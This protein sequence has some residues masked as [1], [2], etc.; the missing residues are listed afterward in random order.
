MSSKNFLHNLAKPFN[1]NTIQEFVAPPGATRL[2]F[3][4]L[5]AVGFNSNPGYYND[6]TGA[7]AVD[8]LIAPPS[9]NNSPVANAGPD[10]TVN[11]GASVTLD[12]TA[13]SDPDNDPLTYQWTI[14]SGPPGGIISNQNSAVAT[15]N[16]PT[17]NADS[18]ATL[19]LKVND[20]RGGTDTDTVNVIVKNVTI[21]PPG[22]NGKIAFM[23][24]R[25]GFNQIYTM[26][27]D[28]TSQTRISTNIAADSM[29]SWSPDKT[30]IAFASYVGGSWEIYTMNADGTG[31]TRLTNNG[32]AD[33]EPSWSPDKTKIA[34]TS[35][36]DGTWKIYTMNADGT[37]QTIL[38]NNGGLEPTWSPDG[39]KIAFSRSG[40]IYVINIDGSGSTNLTNFVGLDRFSSWSPDG[41][42]IAFETTR[43]GNSEIY[44]MNAD[45]TNPTNLS[46]H[47]G[48]DSD[49]SFS[50]DGTKIA[51]I[52]DRSDPFDGDIFTMNSNGSG[53]TR[54]TFTGEI[55][56]YPD[57]GSQAKQPG[58][59]D[60]VAN[61]GPD[62]TVTEGASVTLNGSNSSDPDND[63]LTY[64]WTILSG[65][66]GG[67]ISNQNSA[68]AT[69]NA[70]TVNA[71][72]AAT[73]QLKVNDG[74]GG[75]DTDPV[76]V[77]VKNAVAP[78]SL[79]H[80]TQLGGNDAGHSP[81]HSWYYGQEGT[82]N[83]ETGN[84]NWGTLTSVEVDL[85]S[86]SAASLSF[87][88]FLSK[89]PFSFVDVASV[90]ISQNG[91]PFT[92]IWTQPLSTTGWK[93][94]KIDLSAFDG[95][96]IRAQFKFDTI[97]N[98]FNNFEGWYIDDISISGSTGGPGN[99]IP[100]ANA[101]P[102]QSVNEGT[103]VTLDGS[104]SFDTD[105]TITAYLWQQTAGPLVKFNA[106]TAKPIFTAPLVS[107][108]T[109]LAFQLRVT[110][111]KGA[112]SI[113][114]FVN[115]TVQDVQPQPVLDLLAVIETDGNPLDIAINE[116]FGKLYVL[117]ED[118]F[119]FGANKVAKLHV[120]DVNDESNIKFEKVFGLLDIG[121]NPSSV[122]IHQK[123]NT[124]YVVMTGANQIIRIQ[125]DPT[126]IGYNEFIQPATVPIG[127][128]TRFH[129]FGR[130]AI[131]ETNN[132]GYVMDPGTNWVTRFDLNPTLKPP[133]P[134]ISPPQV[135]PPEQNYP[136][137]QSLAFPFGAVARSD[138]S[139]NLDDNGEGNQFYIV[140]RERGGLAGDAGSLAIYNNEQKGLAIIPEYIRFNTGLTDIVIDEEKNIAYVALRTNGIATVDIDPKKT[141]SS[142]QD[143]II[144]IVSFGSGFT[145]DCPEQPNNIPHRAYWFLNCSL[146]INTNTDRIY[147]TETHAEGYG[148]VVRVI[149]ANTLQ[150]IMV[151]G[152]DKPSME[153]L[154]I[155]INEK[156]GRA[157][158]SFFSTDSF[159]YGEVII[160][161]IEK[162]T[163]TSQ[164]LP[165][166]D[167]DSDG[168]PDSKDVCPDVP[169]TSAN[170]GC[171]PLTGVDTIP[172]LV[173]TPGDITKQATDSSGANVSFTATA[174][175]NVNQILTTSCTPSPGSKFTVGST[176]VVCSVTDSAGNS[177][178]GTFTVTVQSSATTPP[179]VIPNWIKDV[180]AFWCADQIDD[181]SFIQAIQYL[182][183]NQI[184][185]VPQAQS[186]IAGGEQQVPQWVKNNACWWSQG[187]ITN[188]DFAGGIQYLIKIGVIVV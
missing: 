175:D 42:K 26:N 168:I 119:T 110:D 141:F 2:Y 64:Q 188:S 29:P 51:F 8:V 135:N 33:F 152:S 186:G 78:T 147:Y 44:T 61:A 127:T 70:P 145:S 117:T 77:T 85:T 136:P 153:P 123:S 172:P 134:P 16:A 55:D 14:L 35:N 154:E 91:G 60:P 125:G 7:I 57:W 73:L 4:F 5:D 165:E 114:D 67:T 132:F 103:T 13:S 166:S 177:A 138:N 45:G 100:I 128:T 46:N 72:S 164:I 159:R 50:P 30:K 116:K 87:N 106:V 65:P 48:Y 3:G 180:A 40:D 79:W 84:R 120:F 187:Q 150:T 97:D 21:T 109:V 133:V 38:T 58:N 148:G 20:G 54:L 15:Y 1:T 142:P 126:K 93:S 86:Q 62:K 12:G 90:L 111:D 89:E 170:N 146:E 104:F 156:T 144:D 32:A 178:T 95:S 47:P 63:P 108:N 56:I 96:K 66:P 151:D 99:K 24:K 28:G 36:R 130:I 176:Q 122:E 22:G 185:I 68:V 83:Y 113:P 10:K 41:T 19:Q 11:E 59:N 6:N 155:D 80:I 25:D 23:S 157:Y 179:V 162:T 75:T 102:D 184:I 181:S 171:P 173:L 174:I 121:V 92:E 140:N 31:R 101:G 107:A 39:S 94:V 167:R 169:G 9:A 160:Y 131:D 69:Y 18:A 139:K 115:I 149:D 158:V 81:T 76:N 88:H 118:T 49:P 161:A 74:R 27:P 53:Q 52:S 105:G 137:Y 143:R 82:N 124:V 112:T 98:Q 17:V 129:A 182:L 37:G 71:D 34:F 183:D 43:D 163:T